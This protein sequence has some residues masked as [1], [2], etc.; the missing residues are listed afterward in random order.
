MRTL[1]T[2]TMNT[3]YDDYY[4][5]SGLN[6]G[7]RGVQ[8]RF[9]SV[10]SGKGISCARTATALAV[11]N[12]AY[13][14]I[15]ADDMTAFSAKLSGEGIG[16]RLI[17]VPGRARHNLTLIDATGEKVAA[18]FVASG[19]EFDDAQVVTP[20]IEAVL[21]ETRSGDIVTLNGSTC[22]GLPSTTW[23]DLASSLIDRG[24]EVIVDAQNAALLDALDVGGVTLFKPN[25]DEILAIPAVKAADDRVSAALDV[26][27]G[28]GASVPL[29]S[30]G[31]RGVAF[32]DGAEGQV[33]GT[34]PVENPVQ[35]VMAGDAFVAGFAWG[36]LGAAGSREFVRHGLAAAGAHVAGL[37]G[38]ELLARAMGN[39]DRI[40]F[41]P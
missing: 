29:V 6:W 10:C 27:S 9:G 17:P 20:L 24:A 18:H 21:S 37:T 32:L 36:M 28:A 11:P 15:G 30:L 3:G 19:Y 4:T 1:R 26:L 25:D 39:L 16:H 22:T 8:H 33:L 5:V 31:A 7:G 34:C 40:V 38:D 2:V 41:T 14:L 35:S 23:A 12:I 13:A